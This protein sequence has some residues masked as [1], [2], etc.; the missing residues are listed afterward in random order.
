MTDVVRVD[1]SVLEKHSNVI[2]TEITWSRV[3]SIPVLLPLNR[4]SVPG[5]IHHP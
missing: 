3:K 5:G 1:S 2:V 4:N